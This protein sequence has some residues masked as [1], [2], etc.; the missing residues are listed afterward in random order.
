VGHDALVPASVVV[1]PVAH[2]PERATGAATS[3]GRIETVT[4]SI[5][6]E[7]DFATLHEVRATLM[8]ILTSWQPS[9]LIVDLSQLDFCDC[10]GARM[11]ADIQRESIA[12]KTA[13][14]AGNPQPHVA[15][16]ME[17]M[18]GSDEV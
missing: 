9:E 14:V 6:G 10:A 18:R 5:H 16:L 17:W 11:L 13:F 3:T 2:P 8:T 12:R 4:I 7:L 1:T 15:W